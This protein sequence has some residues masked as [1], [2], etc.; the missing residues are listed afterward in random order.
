MCTVEHLNENVVLCFPLH[1][2]LP[3]ALQ[4][5]LSLIYMVRSAFSAD[6]WCIFFFFFPPAK[7]LYARACFSRHLAFPST[8]PALQQRRSGGPVRLP[9]A[10]VFRDE[11]GLQRDN[12]SA[13][14]F[15]HSHLHQRQLPGPKRS[16]DGRHVPA[17][18]SVFP[19]LRFFNLNSLLNMTQEKLGITLLQSVTEWWR[20]FS[21]S[22]GK[23]D[24]LIQLS[25]AD[26]LVRGKRSD[27]VYTSQTAL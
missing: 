5:F 11:E 2:L 12:A 17:L 9:G 16:A 22:K 1:Y 13:A 6:L 27:I 15:A 7:R 10:A 20:D 26:L 14:P 24:T 21:L 8:P 23:H 4:F 18:P 3:F 19:S 25:A